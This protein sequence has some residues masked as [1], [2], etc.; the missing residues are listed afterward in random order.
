MCELHALPE[1]WQ[2][3]DYADFLEQRR[4]LMADIIRRRFE[5]L[6]S[7]LQSIIAES[8]VEEATLAWLSELGFAVAGGLD[9][10]PDGTTPER[11]SYGDVVLDGSFGGHRRLNFCT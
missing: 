8:H 11:A 5:S 10:A 2:E 7:E 9:I 4:H 6:R 1:D 3:M